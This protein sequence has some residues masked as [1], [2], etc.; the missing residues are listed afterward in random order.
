VIGS[1]GIWGLDESELTGCRAECFPDWTPAKLA[2]I[3]HFGR[4]ST[5]FV[6]LL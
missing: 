5:L 1:I 4:L 6:E 3:P 2:T